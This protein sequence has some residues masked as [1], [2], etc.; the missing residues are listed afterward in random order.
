MTASVLTHQE[1]RIM[2]ARARGLSASE[3]AKEV[4]CAEM[5]VKNHLTAI[6]AKLGASSSIEAMWKMGYVQIPG[7]E[8]P[9]FSQCQ[10]VGQCGRPYLHRGQHGGFRPVIRR[11]DRDVHHKPSS[12][13]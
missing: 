10:F 2:R 6:Y 11:E 4:G 9:V 13:P 1:E 3:I 12:D 7:E 5:T 8:P